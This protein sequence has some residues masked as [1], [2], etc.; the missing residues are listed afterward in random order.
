M[1][2]STAIE[3]ATPH[4]LVSLLY[5][6]VASEIAAARGAIARADIGEK[7]RAIGHAVRIIEEG[8]IAPLDMTAGGAIAINLRDLYQ[9]LVQRMTMANLKT[10]D[11]ALA[12]CARL[13]DVLREGWDAIGDQ[14][15]VPARVAA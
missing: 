15:N 2:A 9:Y 6:T 3:G 11:A 5:H 4:K 1:N 12:E 13:I 7:G 10:D 14:V 8:L